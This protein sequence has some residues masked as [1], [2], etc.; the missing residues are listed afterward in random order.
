MPGVKGRSGGQ[1][2][3][4]TVIKQTQ[5]TEKPS[6]A[7]PR[8][9]KVTPGIPQPPTW[10]CEDG[11]IEYERLA[12]MVKEMNVCSLNDGDA[13][14]LAADAL[15]QYKEL[16]KQI[17]RKLLLKVDTKYG[18]KEVRNPLIVARTDAWSRFQ[19][20]LV[21]FGMD[22]SSRGAVTTLPPPKDEKEEFFN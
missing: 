9:P 18:Y 14:A 11:V 19:R 22:P 8:E 1:N 7:N 3:K 2:R 5:G 15:R 6:R 17:G 12:P 4:P 21:R 16:D 20:Q 13:L 10:L